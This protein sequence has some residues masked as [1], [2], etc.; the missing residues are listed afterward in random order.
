MKPYKMVKG[1]NIKIGVIKKGT[2]GT[3]DKKEKVV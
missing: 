3:E 1:L 2:F